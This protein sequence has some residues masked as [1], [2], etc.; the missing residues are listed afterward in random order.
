MKWFHLSI[1]EKPHYS[2]VS[3]YWPMDNKVAMLQNIHFHDVTSEGVTWHSDWY[4]YFILGKF[5]LQMS[6]VRL[7]V[8][9]DFC[10][11]S[12]SLLDNDGIVSHSTSWWLPFNSK[13]YTFTAISSLIVQHYITDMI[14]KI[15]KWSV[16]RK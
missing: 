8:V 15:T 12:Q 11:F 2:A 14:E 10:E 7:D 6:A 5:W 13:Q 4:F 3:G 1:Y 16:T 9:R